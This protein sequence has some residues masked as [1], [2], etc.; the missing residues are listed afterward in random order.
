MP[1][2]AI[3]TRRTDFDGSIAPL[4]STRRAAELRSR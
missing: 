3:V 2:S 4:Y 1:G